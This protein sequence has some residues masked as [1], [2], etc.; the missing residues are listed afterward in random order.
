MNNLKKKIFI[1]NFT[2]TI[3]SAV[4]TAVAINIIMTNATKYALIEGLLPFA[5]AVIIVALIDFY[6]YR[7]EREDKVNLDDLS[8][9]SGG[10]LLPS[11]LRTYRV[12]FDTIGSSMHL[13]S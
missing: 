4:L 9:K 13:S 10:L 1:C 3:S 12:P 11:L 2:K 6:E 5:L 7:C 8:D